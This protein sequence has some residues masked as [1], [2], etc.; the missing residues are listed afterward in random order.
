[1]DT[2]ILREFV[3]ITKEKDELDARLTAKKAEQSRLEQQ[4]LYELAQSGIQ[5][6]KIDGKT[7]YMRA[8]TY[9]SVK[10]GVDPEAAMKVLDDLDL[11][12]FHK[13]RI[14]LQSV[15]AWVRER[16]R[17]EEQIPAEFEAVFNTSPVYRIGITSS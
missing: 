14:T 8:D 17:E 6:I 2:D 9:V 15:S 4:V 13:E 12:D 3:R 16:R 1:M 10:E 5:N 11:G 7:L